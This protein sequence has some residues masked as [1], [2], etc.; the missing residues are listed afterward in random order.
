VK[1][2]TPHRAAL[3]MSLPSL[4]ETFDILQASLSTVALFVTNLGLGAAKVLTG[5]IDFFTIKLPRAEDAFQRWEEYYRRPDCRRE[6]ELQYREEARKALEELK[7]EWFKD[8]LDLVVDKLPA[9]R[10][11]QQALTKIYDAI[12]AILDW[13]EVLEGNGR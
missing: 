2:L 9:K 11:V 1:R 7:I 12:D 4:V 5:A 13:I 6:T 10:V 8:T 3:A